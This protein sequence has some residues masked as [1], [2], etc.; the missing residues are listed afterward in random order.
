M[1]FHIQGHQ[2]GMTEDHKKQHNIHHMTTEREETVTGVRMTKLL[3]N[4][5]SIGFDARSALGVRASKIGV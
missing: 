1:Q 2:K 4:Y 3:A 5:F